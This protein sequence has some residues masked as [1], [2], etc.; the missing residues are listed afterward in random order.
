MYKKFSQGRVFSKST[1][2]LPPKIISQSKMD[3]FDFAKVARMAFHEAGSDF[4]Q[5]IDQLEAEAVKR[6][7][8]VIQVWLKLTS[9]WVGKVV[10]LLQERD[11]FLGGLLPQWFDSDGM[12][13]QKLL[14]S[15]DFDS[16][17]LHSD[18]SK[19]IAE[20]VKSDW[21]RKCSK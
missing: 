21:L 13:M 19:K 5:K 18:D 2:P 16:I 11:Y 20:F 15:P 7:S 14:F 8:L 3:I 1:S 6:G 4:A 12:L 17:Q 9:P 10:E